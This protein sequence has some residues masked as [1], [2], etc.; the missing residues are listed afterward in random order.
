MAILCSLPRLA[1]ASPAISLDAIGP[2]TDGDLHVELVVDGAQREPHTWG[3][4]GCE[5]EPPE[6][7][8][9]AVH[10]VGEVFAQR[11][12]R[13]ATIQRLMTP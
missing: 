13:D 8:R 9:R 4:R 2:D 5:T 1:V 10:E 12:D 6:A 3:I 11:L 7:A